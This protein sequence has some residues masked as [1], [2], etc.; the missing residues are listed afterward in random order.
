MLE[1]IIIENRESLKRYHLTHNISA[2]AS[3]SVNDDDDDD[4]DEKT[5]LNRRL[6]IAN[7]IYNKTHVASNVERKSLLFLVQSAVMH[8]VSRQILNSVCRQHVASNIGTDFLRR[9]HSS[10]G[11]KNKQLIDNNISITSTELQPQPQ[12]QSQLFDQRVAT[13]IEETT[14]YKPAIIII[15]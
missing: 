12:P 13:F 3:S 8:C 15:V 6:P 11:L 14:T 9:Y 7:Y 10:V 5:K 4:V 2:A 1:T